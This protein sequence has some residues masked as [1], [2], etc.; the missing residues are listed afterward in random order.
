MK[1]Y[2]IW[3]TSGLITLCVMVYMTALLTLP[4]QPGRTKYLQLAAD[5]DVEILR[6]AYGVPHIYGDRD[7]DVAFGLGYAQAED[8]FA[9]LQDVILATRGRLAS[10]NGLDATAADF[11]VRWMG[12]W[13]V[14]RAGYDSRVSP[15]ARAVAE[16]YASGVNHYLAKSGV[17][18][19]RALLP[20][21]GEDIIAGFLFKSPLFYGFDKVVGQVF[22]GR[23]GA[24]ETGA[25][26][27][28]A[29]GL[30]LA[31]G[32]AWAPRIGASLIRG[33]QGVAVAPAASGTGETL[34]LVNSHQPLTGPVAWYEA[35][36]KSQQGW[37]M[38]GSTFPGAPLILHGSGPTLGWAN[39]VNKPDLVDVY[40][41]E[42]NPDNAGEYRLD[43]AWVPFEVCDI[44]IEIGIWGPLRWTVTETVKQSA[45]GPVLTAA[46]GT[47]ALRWAG[48]DT[49]GHLDQLLALN[50]A[51]TQADFEAGLAQDGMPSINYV[52]GD[53]DGHIAHYYHA[54]FPN[55]QVE[56]ANWQGVV[57]GTR[58]DLIW[59]GY[60]PYAEVPVT[61][62][63]E[64]GTV[65]NANNRPFVSAGGTAAPKAEHFPASMG[66]E[67]G[68]TNRAYRLRRLLASRHPIDIDAL[69]Q[70]KYDTRYDED[71][72]PIQAF[73]AFLADEARLAA[74]RPDFEAAG[75]DL[76]AALDVLRA[77]DLSTDADNRSAG[78][79]LFTLY[80]AITEGITGDVPPP[81]E[82]TLFEAARHMMQH[83]GRLDPEWGD[84]N[85]LVRGDKSWPLSGGPDVLRAV[86]GWPPTEDG[87][88]MDRAGDGYL[89]F[90]RFG[91]EGRHVTSVHN[92][93][94]A[95]LDANSPHYS[96][97]APLFARQQERV[98][99]LSRTALEATITRRTAFGRFRAAATPKTP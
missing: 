53:R 75:L 61:R 70:I 74:L 44:A 24:G 68:M 56:D 46:N 13:D 48:M 21:R 30:S 83:F 52:Y 14:V 33:S 94:S 97:Q 16:A 12:V 20:V 80:A 3:G 78:L 92:F 95:T 58:S 64:T 99:P 4:P 96:D 72:P 51:R 87:R 10:K 7:A 77:W 82:V 41:L 39:T 79:A 63:P 84:V 2:L 66:I 69:R 54:L 62:D 45:H 8:D 31:G 71:F 42:V 37:D 15:E 27:A 47:F 59:R 1:R 19:H 86:Y 18:V 85:R 88:L 32:T 67:A 60:R 25:A 40:R 23:Y 81:M 55:R 11:L 34:L 36:L 43:G 22:E 93:G 91:A 98:V 90:V 73:R 17:P 29:G 35:R 6:D 9:T 26:N 38:V 28:A 76:S 49:L 57:D 89:Q 65:F 5:Y 50:K